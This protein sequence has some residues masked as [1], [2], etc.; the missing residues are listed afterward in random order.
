MMFCKIL[1]IFLAGIVINFTA[2]AHDSHTHS[3][4]WQACETKNKAAQCS[5]ENGN[6]DLFRG[7]CQVFSESLMCVRNQPIVYAKPQFKGQPKSQTLKVESSGT[8][9]IHH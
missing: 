4:P 8:A 6:G 1:I 9:A 5:Y 2:F 3:A 7:S